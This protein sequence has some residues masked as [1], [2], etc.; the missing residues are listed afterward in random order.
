MVATTVIIY[1]LLINRKFLMTASTSLIRSS[2]NQK[3]R[4]T[5][6]TLIKIAIRRHFEINYFNPLVETQIFLQMILFA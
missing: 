2:D 6:E 5:G 4:S 3:F 1:N